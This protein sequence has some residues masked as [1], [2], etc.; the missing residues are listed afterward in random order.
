MRDYATKNK[1][2]MGNHI[3]NL[4]DIYENT[5]MFVKDKWF[6]EITAVEG[7]SQDWQ[8][9]WVMKDVFDRYSSVLISSKFFI[10]FPIRAL[11]FVA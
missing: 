7:L 5:A 4:K 6:L 11:F 3:K 2:R 9:H 8:D 10:W 1:A